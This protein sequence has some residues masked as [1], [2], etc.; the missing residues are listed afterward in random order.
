MVCCLPSEV[1]TASG[2]PIIDLPV[3]QSTKPEL[4]INLSTAKALGLTVPATLLA[5]ADEVIV[6]SA[7]SP[8]TWMTGPSVKVGL[9]T[10]SGPERAAADRKHSATARRLL[11]GAS[12]GHKSKYR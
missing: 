6:E 9:K 10:S 11:A 1:L 12:G 2:E 3:Q 7:R 5:R 4:F 8:R